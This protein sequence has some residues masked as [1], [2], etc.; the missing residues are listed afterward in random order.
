MQHIEKINQPVDLNLSFNK[1][2]HPF[3]ASLFISIAA[4]LFFT[5]VGW[6]IANRKK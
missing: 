2:L 6:L 1:P 4:T 3:Y 5:A